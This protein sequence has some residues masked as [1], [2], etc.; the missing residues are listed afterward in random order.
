MNTILKRSIAFSVSIYRLLLIAY[1]GPFRDEYRTEMVQA[2]RDCCHDAANRAGCGGLVKLWLHT[3][4][5]LLVSAL[6]ERSRSMRP[7]GLLL[8]V[9]ILGLLT[10]FVDLRNDEIWAS[11]LLL[12]VF[13]FMLGVLQPRNAWRWSL[14]IGIGI[15]AV[16][17]IGL[18]F[19]YT[20]PCHP[21]RV[22]APPSLLDVL[23]LFVVMIPAFIGTYMGVFAGTLT[24]TVQNNALW[25][26]LAILCGLFL[27]F[28]GLHTR[29]VENLY[30]FLTASAFIFGF[31]LQHRTWIWAICLSAGTILAFFIGLAS[32]V[33]TMFPFALYEAGG[34]IILSIVGAYLGAILRRLL[35]TIFQLDTASSTH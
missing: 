13:S 2:F 6:Y 16:H 17:F 4:A 29:Y 24:K 23:G 20:S 12:L 32:G 26:L 14:L 35:P 31:V 28:S 27:G 30:L 3:L 33:H 25:W 34:V 10:G 5:D 18:L 1:P 19:G 22:C 11:L 15:P 21:G 9:L 7:I 8:S